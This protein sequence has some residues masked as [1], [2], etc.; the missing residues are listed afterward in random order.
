[1]GFQTSYYTLMHQLK[2]RNQVCICKIF[3]FW[4]SWA[5]VDQAYNFSI[6]SSEGIIKPSYPLSKK[7][8]SHPTFL[9][10]SISTRELLNIFR[11]C[12]VLD[13]ST[14]NMGNFSPVALVAVIL[15][16][17]ICYF[18]FRNTFL[19]T[20]NMFQLVRIDKIDQTCQR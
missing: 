8:S 12:G 4:M 17:K 18:S 7:I 2:H 13:L 11:H 20:N 14:T 19:E 6:L 10:A 15:S 9:L 5:I 16:V 1:M 3:E